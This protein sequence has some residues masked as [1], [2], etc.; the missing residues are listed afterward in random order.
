MVW[1]VTRSRHVLRDRWI[2]VRAD[3]CVTETG[4]ELLPYYVLEYPDFVHVLAL[5]AESNVIFVRQ[6]RHGL[7]ETSLELPGGVMDGQDA[8]AI[9]AGARELREETGFGA[10]EFRL[11]ARLATD[12]AKLTNRLHL[13]LAENAYPVG[14]PAPE[15]TENLA[16]ER[17]PVT[18]AIRLAR[19]GGIQNAQHVGLLFLGLEA[20]GR[21][22]MRPRG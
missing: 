11:I 14:A 1:T 2:S 19:E 21:I 9:A 4:A 15:V 18:Q 6:Y 22:T 13:L 8:N 17:V 20:A 7:R 5:D 16:I 10:E 3:D 12:P